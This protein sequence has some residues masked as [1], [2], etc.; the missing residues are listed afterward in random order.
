MFGKLTFAAIP[1]T[2]PIIMG[3]VGGSALIT[4]S[5]LALITYYGKWPNPARAAEIGDT[6]LR[7][8]SCPSEYDYLPGLH[9]KL[10]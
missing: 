4:V 7:A 1:V 9:N 5:V 3:A 2:N 10:S 8:Y 6:G